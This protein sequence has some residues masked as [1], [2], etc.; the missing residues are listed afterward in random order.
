M[1]SPKCRWDVD[2]H[3]PGPVPRHDPGRQPSGATIM[4]GRRWAWTANRRRIQLLP[5]HPDDVRRDHPRTGQDHDTLMAGAS[6]VG[7]GTVGSASCQLRGRDRRREGVRPLISRHGFAPFAWYRIVAAGRPRSGW[8][9]AV[10]SRVGLATPGPSEAMRRGSMVALAYDVCSPPALMPSPPRRLRRSSSRCRRKLTDPRPPA[11]STRDAG[12]PSK[13]A[14]RPARRRGAGA[15]S[16]AGSQTR[17]EDADN[18]R[19]AAPRRPKFRPNLRGTSPRPAKIQ[20]AS[21]P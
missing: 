13:R 20:A 18:S 12:N 21:R 3:R 17:R 16:R 14:A 5:R 8:R 4:G 10:L 9:F 2:R 7:F 15:P 19:S 6:G 11:A 1:A